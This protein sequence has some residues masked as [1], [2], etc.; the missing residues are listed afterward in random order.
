M[1]FF[2]LLQ[3]DVPRGPL[4]TLV[5]HTQ[6]SLHSAAGLKA[7]EDVADSCA[8][9]HCRNPECLYLWLE[10][11]LRKI[12][13]QIIGWSMC[14]SAQNVQNKYKICIVI[15]YNCAILYSASSTELTANKK[16]MIMFLNWASETKPSHQC[17]R[18]AEK[19]SFQVWEDRELEN[20][21]LIGE[22]VS[23]DTAEFT[24]PQMGLI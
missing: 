19:N 3:H 24:R 17:D 8:D 9:E 13:I 20:Q 16:P 6:S 11:S 22:K 12:K 5:Y 2:H 15:L 21:I 14:N 23:I 18:F 1:I 4:S 7:D 10:S